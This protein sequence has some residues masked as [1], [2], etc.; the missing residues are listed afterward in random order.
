MELIEP[1]W[2]ET[3]KLL[4]PDGCQYIYIYISFSL[5]SLQI[6]LSFSS[7]IYL[8]FSFLFARTSI[9]FNSSLFQFLP[10]LLSDLT[11]FF[12]VN[13]LLLNNSQMPLAARKNSS[14]LGNC[15]QIDILLHNPCP[16]TLHILLIQFLYTIFFYIL[17]MRC[18]WNYYQLLYFFF[19]HL[20]IRNKR[21]SNV[22]Y[23][24][25]KNCLYFKYGCREDWAA[26]TQTRR[27]WMR[28]RK[29]RNINRL[30][31]TNVVGRAK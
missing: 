14:K 20:Y 5:V 19:L 17:W 4:N 9:F 31:F 12:S 6:Y 13:F 24:E 18:G 10:L 23:R 22:T 21:W 16:S 8:S 11:L 28:M 7:L 27:K 15:F 1:K 29:L 25:K 2:Q 26:E 30:Q 3:Y